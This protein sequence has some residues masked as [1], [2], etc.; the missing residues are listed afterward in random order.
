MYLISKKHALTAF[1]GSVLKDIN[2]N[3]LIEK[4]TNSIE[5]FTDLIMGWMGEV[6]KIARRNQ[7][8]NN[9]II[10]EFLKL[11]SKGLRCCLL[12]GQGNAL[13]YP[14]PASRTSGDIDVWVQHEDGAN[15]DANI[16]RI[17]HLFKAQNSKSVATYHHIDAP[18]I[19]GTPV[20]VHY[21]PQFLFSACHNKRLQQ[22]FIKKA[23]AQFANIVNIGGEAIAV[24]TTEFNIVF[25][26]SHIYN[27]LFHE[28]IGLR[29]IVDYFYTLRK[30]ANQPDKDPT[31][32]AQT[33]AHLGMRKISGA[34]MWILVEQM[35]MPI[36][37]AILPPDERRGRFVLTEIMTSGN[38]GH[39]DERNAKFG[40]SQLGRNAQRLVRDLRLLRYF[41][42]EALSEP[43]FRLWHAIWRKRHN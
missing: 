15:T 8:V 29:Q 41:P 40:T 36:Q 33:I 4:D 12:K 23:E 19:N 31:L 1:I 20:E 25:Q 27:H 10:E 5:A 13:L 43:L 42:S 34:L 9:D 14:N 35:G 21:R 11:E 24:P 38:F 39:F 32:I 22:Y 37:Q 6:V 17:I 16:R 30:Y 2:G 28:G 7:K 18:D 26:L 3:I